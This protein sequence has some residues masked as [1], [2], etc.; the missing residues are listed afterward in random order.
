MKHI[1]ILNPAAGNHKA[2]K[3]FLPEII[4]A[5]KLMDIDYEIHRTVG[6]GDAEHF[7][8][9]CCIRETET[10]LSAEGLRFYA[11]GGDGTL[12][13]VVNGA[14]G[15]D[16]VEVTMIPSGSGNDFVRNFNDPESFMDI[17]RQ[18]NG[19]SKKIDLIRYKTDQGL[20]YGINMFNMG[21]DTEVVEN[22]AKLKEYLISG[23]AAYLLGVGNVFLHK[24]SISLKVQFDDGS[25]YDDDF[26]L[27]AIGNG[28]YY[29]GGFKATPKAELNDGLMDV[30]LV[31]N[32]SRLD[33]IKLVGNYKKGTYLDLKGI[34]N[35]IIY[36][37]C[38]SL[39][40]IPEQEMKLCIDG[41]LSLAGRTDF[42]IIPKAI[43]FSIPR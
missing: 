28:S 26:L 42:E 30:V 24:K 39:T 10:G 33:F 16:H 19:K 6:I 37:K 25:V 8:R 29:G 3:V 22:V 41:E 34:E 36:K 1:F 11:C 32:I 31:K 35:I 5:A 38:T 14:Y 23:P 2:S 12:N 9:C 40:V 20:K 13:E 4:K 15:F 7:T 27:A 18:I 21:L 17:K 43:S